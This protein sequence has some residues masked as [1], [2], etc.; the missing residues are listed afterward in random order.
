MP[1]KKL[2]KKGL[3]FLVG[4][5]LAA[6]ENAEQV[7][8]KHL[9]KG[10]ELFEKGD[11]EQAVLEMKS[12]NQ[13]SEN[14][15]ETYYY[16]ALLDEKNSN[17]RSMRENLGK[18]LELDGEQIAVR[19]KLGKVQLL[20]GEL[21]AVSQQVEKILQKEPNNNIA[22]NLKAVVSFKKG[23]KD[24]ATQIVDTILKSDPANIDALSLKASMYFEANDNEN[25]I[26]T[27]NTAIGVDNKNI[28]L[29]LL[30]I[31]IYAKDNK[32]DD[33]IRE[34]N[35]LIALYPEMENLKISL[36][37]VYSLTGKIDLAEDLLRQIIAKAPDKPE[38][39]VV[40]LEF[41]NSKAKEKVPVEVDALIEANREK[42]VSLMELSKWMLGH[43][44]VD[45]GI[46]SLNIIIDKEGDSKMGMA[47]KTV[48]AEVALNKKDY[49]AVEKALNEL[50]SKDPDYFEAILLKS[51]LLLANSKIDEAIDLLSKAIWS[52]SDSDAANVLLAEAYVAKKDYRQADRY[53][54]AALEINAGNY[55]AFAPVYNN[56]LQANQLET[57]RQ[58]LTR[59]MTA[60][61]NHAYF[62]GKKAELD[63]MEG[64]WDDAKEM[65]RGLVL[66]A[67]NKAVPMYLQGNILQGTGKYQEAI[68]IYER[69]LDE[70]PSHLNCMRNLVSSYEALKARDKAI[71]FFESQHKKFPDNI[72]IVGVLGDLYLTN[73]DYAKSVALLNQQIKSSPK[74]FQLYLALAKVEFFQNK[75]PAASEA[76]YQAGLKNVPD[77][78]QLMMGLAGFYEM[79]NRKNEARKLYEDVLKT[80]EQTLPATN[81]LAS[82]LIDS[83]VP[84]D[85]SKGLAL[86]ETLKDSE[87]IYFLDTYGWAL[88]R[89]G[90][91][92]E[93]LKVL[94]S[95]ILK[96]PKVP[97]FRY[98][99][100]V[101]HAISGNTA[102]AINELKQALTLS[103]RLKKE[104]SGKELAIA[105]L[106]ELQGK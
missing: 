53:Y 37:S 66:L 4:L 47:A 15:S 20:F 94:E 16:M 70:F 72:D 86:A 11:I 23:E 100:G 19:E 8:Q 27:L 10:K 44:F 17:Y 7:A 77:N 80:Q 51:R 48:L 91:N 103:E 13:V 90:K 58:Y 88:I 33:I 85:L 38:P 22:L 82:L 35:E 67:R 34:Y 68:D 101:A 79:T 36:A 28:A 40:L 97:D 25:S 57:A 18:S 24:K 75:N 42:S 50:F 29:R 21:D 92:V 49:S 95:L 102:T 106:K 93:G 59:A 46:K 63:I 76:A 89:N 5:C 56:Y 84:E 98:H 87:N 74:S 12:A 6:C 69:L 54:K 41:L 73:K 39:K 32:I 96:D 81:N 26:A 83:D 45:H 78:S 60:K 43:D 105:K 30:K 9:E 104:F 3:V 55:D 62:M 99:L 2:N 52:K 71:A 31:K 14:R 65:V 64:K 61:P 1:I